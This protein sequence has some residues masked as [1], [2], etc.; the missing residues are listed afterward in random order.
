MPQGKRS[1]TLQ[2]HLPA[3][4][5]HLTDEEV[6]AALEGGADPGAAGRFARALSR[7]EPAAADREILEQCAAGGRNSR[8]GGKTE[9]QGSRNDNGKI[10]LLRALLRPGHGAGSRTCGSDDARLSAG[11]SGISRYKIA[12]G[13]N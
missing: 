11:K 2:S 8:D 5:R 12:V 7:Q 1:L 6:Q 4:G 9:K 13:G 3:P 10:I